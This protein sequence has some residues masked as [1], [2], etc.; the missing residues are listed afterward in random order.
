VE[1][2]RNLG[3]FD[4]IVADKHLYY[5]SKHLITTAK[6][7]K[8][9]ETK[10]SQLEQTTVTLIE[11]ACLE[12]ISTIKK[13]SPGSNALVVGFGGGRII[14]VIKYYA[15]QEQLA[16][17]ALPSTLSHD[18]IFS[19]AAVL[20]HRGSKKKLRIDVQPPLG[21]I[22]D[23][24]VAQQSP[25]LQILSGIGDL[26][27]NVSALDDWKLAHETKGEKI[28]SFAYT[29]AHMSAHSLLNYHEYDIF[30]DK[31]LRKLAYGLIISGM[32][33]TIA[34]SSR[35]A[36]GAEHAISHAID[37]LY[38]ERS[39]F[40][41]L[42]V[43]YGCLLI[44]EHIR[45]KRLKWYKDYFDKVGLTKVITQKISFTPKEVEKIIKHAILLRDRF[46]VLNLNYT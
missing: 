43:A 45:H 14:D 40:H 22:V 46:T 9:Y 44:E 12:D 32:A 3:Q 35:P 8:K 15:S 29:L 17:I 7:Y 10:L 33:M 11:E 18:G 39:T 26:V 19:Q 13:D 38:P 30:S 34:R 42:Q 36:S 16:Y 20:H 24:E 31:Y 37:E 1:V 6:L 21:I 28:N 5:P 41:G 25:R 27:S 23:I 2:N 4:Q